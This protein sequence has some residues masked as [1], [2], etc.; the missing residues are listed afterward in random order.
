MARISSRLP[1]GEPMYTV[2]DGLKVVALTVDDGPSP[3][4][5]PQI[6]AILRR[7]QVTALFSM[8]GWNAP[9]SRGSRGRWR[10]PVT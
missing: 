3:V 4:Y 9:R 2:D 1:Y 10:R 5:T 6:L 8:I 7:Y